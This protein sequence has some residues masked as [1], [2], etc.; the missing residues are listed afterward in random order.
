MGDSFLS[1][2]HSMFNKLLQYE[3]VFKLLSENL[4]LKYNIGNYLINF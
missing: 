2:D 3:K 1:D 4:L